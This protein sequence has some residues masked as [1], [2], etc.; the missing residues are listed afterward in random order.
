MR[1]TAAVSGPK[2]ARGTRSLDFEQVEAPTRE[3]HKDW[4]KELRRAKEKLE[5]WKKKNRSL[6]F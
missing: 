1:R 2:R 4:D 5:K 3:K 6:R